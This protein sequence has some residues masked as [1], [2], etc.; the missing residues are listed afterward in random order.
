MRDFDPDYQAGL[1]GRTHYAGHDTEAYKRGLADRSGTKS[2]AAMSDAFGRGIG[3]IAGG[4]LGIMLIGAVLFFATIGVMISA[5]F[6]PVAGG[7]TIAV[8]LLLYNFVWLT[9][10]KG[11]SEIIALLVC[12]IPGG[13]LF[14]YAMKL[15]GF[16]AQ[17]KYYRWTRHV[18]RMAG[19]AAIGWFIAMSLDGSMSAPYPANAPLSQVFPWSERIVV[20]VCLVA[21]HFVSRLLDRKIKNLE[22][23]LPFP[24]FRRK[25]ETPKDE[26]HLLPW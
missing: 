15:E 10:M 3:G 9:F 4:P 5:A 20:V 18:W 7:L 25:K 16:L 19:F 24:L 8:Y 1:E 13:I 23:R 17:R 21:G 22:G 6:F 11:V 12:L 2:G 26:P 14:F